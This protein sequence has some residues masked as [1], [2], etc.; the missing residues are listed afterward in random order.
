MPFLSPPFQFIHSTCID[1]FH[2]QSSSPASVCVFL[3]D[4]HR[5][6]ENERCCVVGFCI[7][8]RF[9]PNYLL[10][11]S[12]LSIP[13]ISFSAMASAGASLEDPYA[14][15]DSYYEPPSLQSGEG[16]VDPLHSYY[17]GGSLSFDLQPGLVGVKSSLSSDPQTTVDGATGGYQPLLDSV[18]E[19]Q[20]ADY[21]PPPAYADIVP[22]SPL[23]SDVRE[24]SSERDNSV[25]GEIGA[26][27]VSD[28]PPLPDCFQLVDAQSS[29]YLQEDDLQTVDPYADP[30][31]LDPGFQDGEKNFYEPGLPA[32]NYYSN[33]SVQEAASPSPS[34]SSAA[35]SSAGAAELLSSTIASNYDSTPV[36]GQSVDERE[37]SET[38]MKGQEEE[39]EEEG[40][41]DSLHVYVD[42]KSS[43]SALETSQQ[44][45]IREQT[46]PGSQNVFQ[47]AKSIRE[48]R[49]QGWETETMLREHRE[50][51][52]RLRTRTKDWQKEFLA[53]L[54][55][56]E[57]LKTKY[58][59]ENRLQNDTESPR[60]EELGQERI[61]LEARLFH[62]MNEFSHAAEVRPL[63]SNEWPFFTL[64]LSSVIDVFL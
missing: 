9:S 45:P 7:Q 48:L 16:G 12:L 13:E 62:L 43:S 49:E 26:P 64:C 5:F 17:A 46:A 15:V 20:F 3:S 51:L 34:S 50:Q 52:A 54:D 41:N 57:T 56:G 29:D 28:G 8:R 22:S 39:E 59:T 58:L 23:A 10:R 44:L 38:D 42:P 30:S 35:S 47:L 53:I 27:E 33:S 40:Q 61:G 60:L 36:S 63:S 55:E 31:Q 14:A 2:I 19:S 25:A 6:S 32:Q 11:I 1:V 24:A 4:D 18:Y 21:T 37:R